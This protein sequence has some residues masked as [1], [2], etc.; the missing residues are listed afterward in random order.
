MKLKLGLGQLKLGDIFNNRVT[1]WVT[2]R[3]FLRKRM[4]IEKNNY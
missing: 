1:I 4:N 3:R 2:S